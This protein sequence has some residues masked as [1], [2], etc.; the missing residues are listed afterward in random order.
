MKTKLQHRKILIVDDNADLV[1]LLSLY[2]TNSGFETFGLESGE[3]ALKHIGQI[4]PD[5]ILLDILMPNMDGFET[6]ARLKENPHTKDIPIVF[7][8]ALAD[9]ENKIKGF[10]MG[11]VDYITKPLQ[12]EEVLARVTTHLTLRQ[13]QH[14]LREQ[15]RQLQEEN[16][17]QRRVQEALRESRE[18]YRLL[19]ENSTDMIAR[20]TPKAVYLYVSPACHSLLGYEIEEMVGKAEVD[21]AH[22]ADVALIE[23]ANRHPDDR[24][25]VA[26]YTYRARRKDGSYIWLETTSRRVYD[27][28]TGAPLEIIT[29]SRN[30]TERE[31]AGIALKQ[32][33]DKLEQRVMERTAEL[34]KLNAALE[35]FVPQEF[36]QFLGKK[37]IVEV[38]LGDQVQRDMTIF[39]SDIRSFTTFSEQMSPQENFNFINTYLN[40]VSPI[41]RQYHGF[42]D[43]YIGDAVMALFP[44]EVEHALQAAIAIKQELAQFNN[45]RKKQGAYPINVGTG[46][47]TGSLMLGTIGEVQRMEGTVISDNVNLTF[48]LEGLTKLYGASIVISQTSLYNLNQPSQYHFRFLDRVRVKGKTE[49]VSVFEVF[50]GDPP[51]TFDLK[52]KTLTDFEKG[53]LY[54]HSREFKKAQIQFNRVITTNPVDKAAQLYYKRAKHYAQHGVPADWEG[55]SALTDK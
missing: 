50:E 19:A 7:L 45:E 44:D 5:I 33:H 29:V 43:K 36:L 12:G 3:M 31:E 16:I 26:K 41:I 21:F 54:Y 14:D 24:Q 30:V 34:I 18:H 2:L 48:R 40:R 22:P 17:K 23:E 37:S 1:K 8:T 46:I 49:P 52:L 42:I 51:E 38:A 9:T 6:C 55:V 27:P 35:R 47:H 13:L 39:F 20:Q 10:Q 53:L 28:Q 25:P 32:A 4:N 11:A 15:N